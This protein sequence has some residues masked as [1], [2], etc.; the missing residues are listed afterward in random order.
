MHVYLG[1]QT[2]DK[3]VDLSRN[4]FLLNCD[5]GA[6]NNSKTLRE[7]Q[8]LYINETKKPVGKQYYSQMRIRLRHSHSNTKQIVQFKIS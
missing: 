7:C 1:S 5:S 6:V 3:N 2:I 4:I 8:W